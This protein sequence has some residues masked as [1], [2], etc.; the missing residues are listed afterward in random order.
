[1]WRLLRSKLPTES[2]LL[3]RLAEAVDELRHSFEPFKQ[4]R[5]EQSQISSIG[6]AI[7]YS[8][9]VTTSDLLL[10]QW[11]GIRRFVHAHFGSRRLRRKVTTGALSLP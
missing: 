2:L 11:S 8:I 7:N 5:F 3:D 4:V 9:N 1:M 6:E 10:W